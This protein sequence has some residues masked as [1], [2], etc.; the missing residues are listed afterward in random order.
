MV[1]PIEVLMR[2]KRKYRHYPQ[3]F[4]EEA[5]ALITDQRHSVQKAVD[6]L[7]IYSN[8]L[9]HW[10]RQLEDQKLGKSLSEN[11]RVELKEL[12]KEVRELGMEKT[13]FKKASTLFAKKILL[14]FSTICRISSHGALPNHGYR[15]FQVL[16]LVQT[17][18]KDY[19]DR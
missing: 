3:E 5:L 12:R 14:H 1:S 15:L 13:I 17:S 11:E 19:F 7:G 16:C 8:L 4:K 9:Y 2:E 6:S 10:Q 18:R